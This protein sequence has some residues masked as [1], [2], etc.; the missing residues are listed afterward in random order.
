MNATQLTRPTAE[1]VARAGT[2]DVGD[3][4][5]AAIRA[6]VLAADEHQQTKNRLERERA[7]LD[8][9]AGDSQAL[10][11]SGVPVLSF[12]EIRKRSIDVDRLA[13]RWPAAYEDVVTETTTHR[14]NIV[15]EVRRLLRRRTWRAAMG[16][17]VES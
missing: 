12:E 2:C 6:Y 5:L 16:R 17:R 7:A 15:G 3:L 8:A 1:P 14:L 9:L 10:T 11:Y 4:T 13:A